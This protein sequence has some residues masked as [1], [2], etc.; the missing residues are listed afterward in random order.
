MKNNLP[1]FG[2]LRYRASSSYVSGVGSPKYILG[3]QPMM[4]ILSRR[5]R[6]FM[7]SEMLGRERMMR[8]KERRGEKE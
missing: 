3:T 2:R 6:R 5:E 4:G 1:V 7:A 8:W